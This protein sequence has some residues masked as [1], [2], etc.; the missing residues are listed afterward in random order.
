MEMCVTSGERPHQEGIGKGSGSGVVAHV[1]REGKRSAKG[2]RGKDGIGRESV[3]H[4]ARAREQGI[5]I[6]RMDMD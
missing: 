5:A 4:R 1:E 2:Q 3:L 6:T